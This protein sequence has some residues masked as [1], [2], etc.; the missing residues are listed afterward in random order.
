[1]FRCILTHLV[2]YLSMLDRL[3]KMIERT[4]TVQI[5]SHFPMK[6]PDFGKYIVEVDSTSLMAMIYFI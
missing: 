5:S 2:R 6:F 3:P 1:S 4:K